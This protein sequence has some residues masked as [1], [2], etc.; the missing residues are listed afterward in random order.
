MPG[1]FGFCKTDF[2]VLYLLQQTKK[3]CFHFVKK[4]ETLGNSFD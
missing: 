3:H 4:G 1:F 2:E